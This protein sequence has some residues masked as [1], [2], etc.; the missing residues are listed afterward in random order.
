MG[1]LGMLQRVSGGLSR[2]PGVLRRAVQKVSE[3]FRDVSGGLCRFHG[4]YRGK[5]VPGVA[6]AFL[7]QF[8]G[9]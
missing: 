3:G 4:V 5:G 9:F 2:A 6:G 8:K 1:V 7:G